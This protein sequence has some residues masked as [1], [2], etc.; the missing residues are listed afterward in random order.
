MCPKELIPADQ[1]IFA[2]KP[3][4]FKRLSSADILSLH[5]DFLMYTES[6]SPVKSMPY[7]IL[8]SVSGSPYNHF[9]QR[10]MRQLPVTALSGTHFF[11]ARLSGADRNPNRGCSQFLK[12]SFLVL[13]CHELTGMHN[14]H[15]THGLRHPILPKTDWLENLC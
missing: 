4:T 13:T 5:A 3:A 1:T 2:D 10:C 9:V 6:S 7:F 14:I 12:L 11:T 8:T 15:R